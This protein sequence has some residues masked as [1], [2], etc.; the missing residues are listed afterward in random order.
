[1]NELLT[2]AEQERLLGRPVRAGLSDVD[3]RRLRGASVVVTGA[4]GSIGS[5]LARQIAACRPKR[6]TLVDHSEHALFQIERELVDA[7]CGAP[8]MPVL[9]DVTRTALMRQTMY[10]SRAQVVFHAAAYK[11]VTMAERAVCAAA[12]VN[13]LGTTTVLNAA[14]E[15]GARFT[16]ISSDKAADPRSVMG[17][18][19]RLAEIATLGT[20][21][22]VRASV[23]RFGNVLASSGSFVT[24]MCERLA[25]G[26]PIV[27]THPDATR[28]FMT[29]GEAVSLVIKAD[30]L[31]RGADTLWFDM[32]VPV[33][34]GD[35]AERLQQIWIDRGHQP[36]AT[37]VVGLRP[38]EKLAEQL[39]RQG[40]EMRPTSDP[41]I[42][43]ARQPLPGVA[44]VRRGLQ[45]IARAVKAGDA[46]GA[47]TALTSAVPEFVPSAEAISYARVERLYAR[48]RR[49][50]SARSA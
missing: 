18:T 28:Y 27:L 41:R 20:P 16:L 17:A 5:E 30:R 6:L 38:G 46:F 22:A 31:S 44:E 1:V 48:T 12:A 37:E 49:F 33:R 32:G 50:R 7:G 8:L 45:A 34:I 35:L 29:V 14:E 13:V 11:H 40:I 26:R 19:K 3:R 24:I 36:V 42:V 25:Q 21:R 47:L 2:A 43:V 15:V 23:V 10:Q 4:G 39:T 9:A